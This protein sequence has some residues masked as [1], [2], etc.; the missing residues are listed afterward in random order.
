MRMPQNTFASRVFL[1][2]LIIFVI[3]FALAMCESK[4]DACKSAEYA[5]FNAAAFGVV[6]VIYKMV[7]CPCDDPKRVAN[8]V[9]YVDE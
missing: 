3:V 8:A 5:L 9:S 2:C 4:G 1:A 6:V 7:I